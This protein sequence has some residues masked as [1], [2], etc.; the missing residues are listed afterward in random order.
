M[1]RHDR[2]DWRQNQDSFPGHTS[3]SWEVGTPL[4]NV[5]QL[6]L[7]D[8]AAGCRII[9]DPSDPEWKPK[10]SEAGKGE[11]YGVPSPKIQNRGGQRKCQDRA[12]AASTP[13]ENGSPRVF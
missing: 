13:T 4:Q 11:K 7:A 12:G 3:N 6:R 2:V 10:P 1:N 9:C 5:R 8:T